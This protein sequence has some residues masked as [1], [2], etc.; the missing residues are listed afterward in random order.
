MIIA[1]IIAT[2]KFIS[3]S[4]I[5]LFSIAVNVVRFIS[6][7]ILVP[8]SNPSVSHQTNECNQ[9]INKIVD[10]TTA[11]EGSIEVPRDEWNK[12]CRYTKKLK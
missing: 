8:P 10:K 12:N 3:I 7:T 2:F 1:I 4:V 11:G 6:L 9:D 5:V